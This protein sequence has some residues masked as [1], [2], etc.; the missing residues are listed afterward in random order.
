MLPFLEQLPILSTPHFSWEKSKSPTKPPPSQ[1]KGEGFPTVKKLIFIT[2]TKTHIQILVVDK[3]LFDVSTDVFFGGKSDFYKF[4]SHLFFL[5][6][7]HSLQFIYRGDFALK[8]RCFESFWRTCRIAR[9]PNIQEG[10]CIG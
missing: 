5:A 3:T 7:C 10:P 6:F 4:G 9:F 1:R 2:D 8:G